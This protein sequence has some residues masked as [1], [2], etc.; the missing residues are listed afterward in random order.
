VGDW[1]VIARHALRESVRRRVLAVVGLLSI[2]FLV[3]FGLGAR[4]AFD[5]TAQFGD[6]A[7]DR[8]LTGATLLGLAMFAI[9]FLGAVLAVFLTHDAVRGDAERGLLQPVVV[10]PPGRA[11]YLAGRLAAALVVAC[12]YVFVMFCASVV[13]TDAAGDFAP[14]AVAGPGLALAGAVA[15]LACTSLLGSVVLSGTANGIAIFMVFGAGLTGGLLGE[16]GDALDVQT[17]EDVGRSIAWAL[18]FEAL[19]LDGLRQLTAD[20]PG[21]AGELVRLGPFGGARDFGPLLWPWV[22]FVIVALIAIAIRAFE[23]RDL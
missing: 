11:A 4:E 6:G 15:L 16:I 23:A 2:A 8:A 14:G 7:D 10:R 21:L 12:P 20:V 3:L 17:L 9:L 22:A 13:L 18:P 1:H 19:Y 5:T